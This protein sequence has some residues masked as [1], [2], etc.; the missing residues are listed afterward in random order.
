[1]G[2]KVQEEFQDVLNEWR[3]IIFV[4]GT[5]GYLKNKQTQKIDME[6]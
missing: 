3:D 2:R 5:E 1:M 4:P 6:E